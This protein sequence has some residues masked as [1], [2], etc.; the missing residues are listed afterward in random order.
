MIRSLLRQARRWMRITTALTRYEAAAC[1]GGHDFARC[2]RVL[3]IGGNSGEFALQLCRKYP[4]IQAT[5]L[6]LP[7]VCEVGRQHI[8]GQPGAERVCFLAGDARTDDLPGG[9][10]AVVFKSMLHDW[11]DDQA[12]LLLRRASECLAPDGVLVIFER[13]PLELAA[14]PLPYSMLPLLLL[15]R[16][17]RSPTFYVDVLKGLEF[18]RVMVDRIDLETPFFLVA[19]S[20]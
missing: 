20:R 7:V 18:E 17:F 13:G 1:I 2:R 5:V 3:D 4:H 8:H 9:F 10:D 19:A 14:Q 6:D 16:S 15:F 12:R 11:P